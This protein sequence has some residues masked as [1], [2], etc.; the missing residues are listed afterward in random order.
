MKPIIPSHN[1]PNGRPAGLLLGAGQGV[2][3]GS[4]ARS[5][6]GGASITA[7]G[8]VMSRWPGAAAGPAPPANNLSIQTGLDPVVT[9]GWSSGEEEEEAGLEM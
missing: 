5:G 2:H 6:G 1:L 7:P 4:A 8:D 3:N 9:A